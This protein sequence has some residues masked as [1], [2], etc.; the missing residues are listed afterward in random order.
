LLARTIPNA[1]FVALDSKNPFDP[2][3]RA[4]VATLRE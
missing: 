4:V 1:R 2:V 3:A